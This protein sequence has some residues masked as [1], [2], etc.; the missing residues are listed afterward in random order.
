MKV[1]AAYMTWMSS[2]ARSITVSLRV[3]GVE[4]NS[5]TDG[6]APYGWSSEYGMSPRSFAIGPEKQI[7]IGVNR[8]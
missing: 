3:A 2:Q 8:R 7:S 5:K 6:R 1:L 4:I